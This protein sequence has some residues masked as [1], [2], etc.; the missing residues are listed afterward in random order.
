MSRIGRLLCAMG[1]HDWRAVGG[2]PM[3]IPGVG[4]IAANATGM[5]CRRC[6]EAR[7][8][9]VVKDSRP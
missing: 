6:G 3:L 8:L 4:L 1:R 7:G 5:E 9:S 2:T